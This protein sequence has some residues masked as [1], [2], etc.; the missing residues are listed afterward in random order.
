[1]TL[2]NHKLVNYRSSILFRDISIDRTG[3]GYCDRET[4]LQGVL[5]GGERRSSEMK[6]LYVVPRCLER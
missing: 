1:M 2:R 4:I 3:V 6:L 5:E